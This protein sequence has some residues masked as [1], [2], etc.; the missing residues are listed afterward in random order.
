MK[1]KIHDSSFT[2]IDR[3]SLMNGCVPEKT[4]QTL[5][6]LLLVGDKYADNNGNTTN[7]LCDD[8]CFIYK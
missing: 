8:R 2:F 6:C 4:F 5:P 3:I 1:V 7:K